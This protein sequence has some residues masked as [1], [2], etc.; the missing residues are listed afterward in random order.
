M[1]PLY[2][3][4]PNNPAFNPFTWYNLIG[5]AGCVFWILAYVL[6][7]KKCFKDRTYGLPLVAICL[8]FGWEILASFVF[9]NPV[10]LWHAFDRIWLGVDVLL[11]YQLLRWGKSAQRKPELQRYFYGVVAVS[12]G[13]GI[14]GQ[15]AFVSSYVDRLG[16]VGAFGVNLIMSILFISFYLER[17]DTLSGISRGGAVCKMLGTLGTSIECHYVVGLIDPEMQGLA[18]LTFLCVCIFVADCFYIYL[19]FARAKVLAG[20][21]LP[22]TTSPAPA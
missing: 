17:K 10:A 13:V 11:V 3:V 9:P 18:F 8:N 15:Y 20:E 1:H 2:S 12:F 7:L 19:V 21:R 4:D 6:I 16:L 14:W 5:A 22:A